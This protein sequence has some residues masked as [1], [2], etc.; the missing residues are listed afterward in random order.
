MCLHLAQR[1]L[2]MQS[3]APTVDICE[4]LSKGLVSSG[5]PDR[6]FVTSIR[7]IMGDASISRDQ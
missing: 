7:G 6:A 3:V 1:R 5:R 2:A 4:P